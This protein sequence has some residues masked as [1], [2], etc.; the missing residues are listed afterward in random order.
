MKKLIRYTAFFLLVFCCVFPSAC[1]KE[2]NA[3]DDGNPDT[4]VIDP[5]VLEV[6]ENFIDRFWDDKNNYFFCNQTKLPDFKHMAG[7]AFGIYTDFW[8]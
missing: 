8:L 1:G 7:P 3:P 5:R 4:D 6:T 2:S